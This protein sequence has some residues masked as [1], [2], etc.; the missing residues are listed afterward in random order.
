MKIRLDRC[1]RAG[2]LLSATCLALFL[3]APPLAADDLGLPPDF[4]AVPLPGVFDKPTDLAFASEGSL[5]LSQQSG[6]V[7]RLD[8]TETLQPLSV[9]DLTDEVNHNHDRGLLAIALHPGFV[10]DGGPTSWLYLLYTVSPVPGQDTTFDQDDMYS[11]SRLTRYRL[12]SAAGVVSAD[13]GSRDVL[14]GNQLPDGSVPDA[15]ASVHKSHSNGTLAFAD[16]GSLIVTVGDGAHMDLDDVGGFDPPAFDNWVHPDTGLKGPHPKDQD[17]GAYRSQDLRSLAGKVLRLDP[18]TG[19][20]LPS[21]PFYTGTPTD[22]AS[23]VWALGLRNPFRMTLMPGTGAL[24]PAL[25]QPGVMAIGDVG[26]KD[27]EELDLSVTGGENYGWPCREGLVPGTSTYLNYVPGNPTKVSCQT[28]TTGVPT[29]PALVWNHDVNT[30]VTPSGVHVDE[31]GAPLNGFL[32]S[33]AI[34]GAVYTGGDYPSL[35]DGRL[36]I[37]DWVEDWIKTVVFD[38]NWAV[39]EVRDFATGVHAIVG[40]AQHPLTGDLY[41]LERDDDRIVHL[42][43][44]V[45]NGTP[46]AVASVSPQVGPAPL[47]ANFV[48]SDSTDPDGDLLDYSWDFGDGSPTSD[49]A[50]PQHTYPTEGVF[51]VTLLVTDPLG[52]T[53]VAQ[54]P[55][56]V[57]DTPVALTILS[58]APG[59]TY[60]PPTSVVLD[61]FALDP[62]GDPISYEWTVDFH[63]DTHVHSGVFSSSQQQ[64]VLPLDEDADAEGELFYYRI[65]LTATNTSGLSATAHVFVYPAKS[66]FDPS[67]TSLL[68]TKVSTL[69]PPVPLG[70][71]EP[72]AE[73]VRD[74]KHPTVGSSD[75]LTQWDSSHAGEQGDD[76]WIGMLLP[77]VPGPESRFVALEFQEGMHFADGGWW[78]EL[79]VEVRDGGVWTPA[80]NLHVTPPYPFPSAGHPFFDGTNFQTYELHFDPTHGDAIRLRGAPGGSTGFVSVAELRAHMIQTT[81]SAGRYADITAQGTIIAKLF[82]L[83]PP[84]PQG[85][86]NPDPETI[87]NG[88]WAPIGSE[89]AFAQFDTSHGGDQ[90]EQDWIGYDFGGTRS[91][92]R[93]D[94]QEGL[95]SA[96]GGGFDR[97]RIEM[98]AGEGGPW[99]VIHGVTSTP[100]YAPG[101]AG[102]AYETFSFSFDPV[103]AH[104]IRLTGEPAGSIGFI[105]VGELR[106]HEPAPPD[107]CGWTPYGAGLGGANLLQL[108]SPTPAALGLPVLLQVAGAEPNSLGFLGTSF[109]PSALPVQGGTLLLDPGTLTLIPLSYATDGSFSVAATLPSQPAWAGV[110]VWFQAIAYGQPSPFAVRFSDGLQLKLCNW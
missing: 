8:P 50:D 101:L 10:P 32:G 80:T 11:F 21:N 29:D 99:Q 94:F 87:R 60:S 73:I 84:Q 37:A 35:Y 5:Y 42:R 57:G 20:G 91:L 58:P 49:A 7:W 3:A 31:S 68:I 78:K 98:Q 59:Q 39:V 103:L 25:G 2:G 16:D 48:G 85:S 44:A 1:R 102:P 6:L 43:Y 65:E 109:G 110:E 22:N 34:G 106:V 23:R 51:N 14:L 83:I 67:G 54:L 74:G 93:I 70:S 100:D 53:G 82:E 71:G 4:E 90:G 92:A 19:A 27:W 45:E 47:T 38:E 66:V 63:H 61:G 107:G 28:P 62:G 26:W 89:S 105:S 12:T 46:V 13:L 55:V 15:I 41:W 52:L 104:G 40:M 56:F 108:S 86:G 17:A 81:P 97:L 77:A 33:C 72:D 36:F 76:D 64:A 69:T 75:P 24:D 30:G 96:G 95:H 9:L 18:Q 79:A 88:T